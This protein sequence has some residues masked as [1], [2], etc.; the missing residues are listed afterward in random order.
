MSA[1]LDLRSREFNVAL[2][3][4]AISLGLH[5]AFLFVAREG[6]FDETSSSLSNGGVQ[7][8]LVEQTP[9]AAA[10]VTSLEST[11]QPLQP[12]AQRSLRTSRP[13]PSLLEFRPVDIPP[14]AFDERPYLPLSKLTQPPTP[15]HPVAVPYPE[16]TAMKG[17]V[18]TR[19]TLFIDEQGNVA[20]V[21][22]GST[23]LP[24]AFVQAAKDAFEPA[25]FRPGTL[26]G[27]S[28][29]AKMVI[30]VEF[31]DHGEKRPKREHQKTS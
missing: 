14:R 18:T 30:D 23:E 12:I 7:V 10:P 9:V 1:P 2:A 6:R 15:V 4:V 31:E 21:V 22:V 29:K 5:L 27:E 17:T 25:K 20:R 19:L 26:N 11:W 13:Y 16:G 3:C 24:D 8:K 28:V